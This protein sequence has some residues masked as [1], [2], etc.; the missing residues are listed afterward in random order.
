MNNNANTAESINNQADDKAEKISEAIKR[1][2]ASAGSLNFAEDLKKVDEALANAKIRIE[3]PSKTDT[4]IHAAIIGGTV[5][6]I[7]VVGMLLLKAFGVTGTS[8]SN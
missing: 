7:T 6:G 2:A 3:L 8:S 4:L 5:T 1:A